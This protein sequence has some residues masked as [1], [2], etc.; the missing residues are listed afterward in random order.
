[1]GRAIDMV[2]KRFGRLIV[3]ER[4]GNV[5]PCAAWRCRCDCG[6]EIVTNGSCL[7]RG[8]TR[9]CGCLLEERV[10]DLTGQR[11][12]MLTVLE[13]AGRKRNRVAWR[14]RCDCGKESIV[15]ALDLRSGDVKSCGCMKGSWIA[16]SKLKHGMSG[17]R[18]YR[19]WA[20]MKD[21]CL[22]RNEKEYPNYG[23]RGIS[24]C[25]EWMEFEPFQKWALANG[26]S[27]KLTIDRID[28]N[29]D[30]CPEN[31]R[32]AT[33]KEQANN[34]R[35]NRFLEFNG[36]RQTVAQW[37]EEIGID[38]TT[39]LDRLSRHSIEEALSMP[40]KKTTHAS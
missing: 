7:R 6:N 24:V 34:K 14:C 3:L 37:A 29:G 20:G 19:V 33:W 25:N 40:P 2:G 32:W 11:F 1:M 4:A 9:S 36:R 35:N 13:R 23:E 17:S 27:D 31:C 10:I 15:C 12:G 30:Y 21:R 38:W 18:L 39:L 28:V 26:Y 22:N 5:G 8:Q 16:E